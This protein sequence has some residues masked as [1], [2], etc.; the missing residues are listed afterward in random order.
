MKKVKRGFWVLLLAIPIFIL[1]G[2]GEEKTKEKI[3]TNLV[4]SADGEATFN[5][6]NEA[7][8]EMVLT[9]SSG[10]QIEFQLI[11]ED[12][13][14]MYTYSANKM[15]MQGI[16]EKKLQAG[17]EW[18]IPLNLQSELAEVPA[19]SYTLIVWSTAE[20]LD[21]LKVETAYDWNGNTA[22]E[23]TGK[24]V[25]KTEEVIYNDQLDSHSIK[26]E[27]EDGIS[28]VMY[29]SEVA[30][31]IFKDIEPGTK[32]LVD[33]VIEKEHKVVQFAQIK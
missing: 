3:S 9:T 11:N 13:E 5:I 32:I 16:V 33:Y 19:G 20:G 25:V 14:I 12:K 23:S 2:C 10:Q 18:K 1:T 7:K 21:D 31:S 17:E 30:Q 15:F 27:N 29:L 8:E 4:I 6:K 28:E 26:V 24:L 22:K